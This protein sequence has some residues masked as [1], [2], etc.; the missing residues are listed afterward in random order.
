MIPKE[1]L[2]D[3]N[4]KQF[5]LYAGLLDLA[6]QQGLK[7]IS[8]RLI[9]V[10]SE[11]NN[12]TAICSAEVETERG[13]FSGLGDA[14]PANVSRAMLTVTIRLAET[15][16]KARALRDA[17]NV[18]VAALEELGEEVAPEPTPIRRTDVEKL[19]TSHV[20]NLPTSVEDPATESQIRAIQRLGGTIPEGLG[21]TAASALIT[22][23]QK[24]HTA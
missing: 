7:R 1:F 24:N 14:S 2:V 4:G 6:H 22:R 15:R 19:S 10:P 20:G 16:A 9:Q 18:G 23:L 8:T 13:T 21:K 5:V 12:Q 3:R 17:V 11:E